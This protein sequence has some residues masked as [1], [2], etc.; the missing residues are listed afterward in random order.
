MTELSI[1]QKVSI[2]VGIAGVVLLV[3]GLL[4]TFTGK[5]SSY[6]DFKD[7]EYSAQSA[8]VKSVVLDIGCGNVKITKGSRLE[9][10]IT[11]AADELLDYSLT[12][13]I[14]TVTYDADYIGSLYMDVKD[15]DTEFELVL[16]GKLLEEVSVS[17]GRGS[18]SL[19]GLTCNELALRCDK[20]DVAASSVN[21]NQSASLDC[22]S[23]NWK[24]DGCTISRPTVSGGSGNV[25]VVRSRLTGLKYSGGF[26]S[27]KLASCL[28]A[29]SSRIDA[30]FAD[31]SVLLLGEE[32]SY[33]F[34]FDK[35]RGDV[36]VAGGDWEIY[37]GKAGENGISVKN[38]FGDVEISFNTAAAE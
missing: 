15:V 18:V 21:V 22:G 37:D 17:V 16:P 35:G 34:S 27:L 3:L 32:D 7:Y 9:M 4:L 24:L 25:T 2:S 33:G 28:V 13:N 31:V 26:G 20:G 14:L 10:K 5:P 8:D 12:N 6:F 30:G 1:R 36:K 23:G 19:K 11:N 29:G 38:G